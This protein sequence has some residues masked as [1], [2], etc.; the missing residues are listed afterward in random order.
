MILLQPWWNTNGALRENEAI[1]WARQRVLNGLPEFD[2]S[3]KRLVNPHE[4]PAGLELALHER[5]AALILS[6]RE[7]VGPRD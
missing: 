5:K 1:N 6:A 2:S 3:I 4:Y 7:G